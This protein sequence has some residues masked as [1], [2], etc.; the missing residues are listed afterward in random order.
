VTPAVLNQK[1]AEA[2]LGVGARWLDDAPI[3]RV[4]RRKPGAAKPFWG[5]RVADLD[6]WL[7][8]RLVQPGET[9]RW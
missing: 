4:D 2:Y 9:S 6:A 1:K 8:E 5:W 3:P 7:E